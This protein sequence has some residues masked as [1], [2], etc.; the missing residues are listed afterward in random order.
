MVVELVIASSVINNDSGLLNLLEPG[1]QV[2]ADKGFPGIKTSVNEKNSILVM[3][4]F[5]HT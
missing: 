5:M 4:P 1:D 2:M 3:P